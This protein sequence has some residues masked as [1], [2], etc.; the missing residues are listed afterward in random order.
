MI[1]IPG[2]DNI[3]IN[4]VQGQTAKPV[5]Q[6]TRKSK[7]TREKEREGQQQQFQERLAKSVRKLNQAIE[8]LDSPLRFQI[9][10]RNGSWLVQIIDS[11]TNRLLREVPPERV[12]DVVG[13]LQKA[14][15]LLVDELI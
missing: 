2:V 8:V 11:S 7:I 15:G 4:Q 12:M 14:L 10:E 1:K 5:V 6:E 13:R 9:V 3:I